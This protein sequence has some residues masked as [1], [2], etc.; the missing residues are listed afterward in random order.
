MS[1]YQ[2][3]V[4]VVGYVD[5]SIFQMIK[6]KQNTVNTGNTIKYGKHGQKP[7]V[8]KVLTLSESHSQSAPCFIL[9]PPVTIHLHRESNCDIYET[10]KAFKTEE[11]LDS[12]GKL[13]TL[14]SE[15]L[16]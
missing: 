16:V 13:L 10:L 12:K 2:R 4:I 5:P 7:Y 15:P 14:K 9:A 8:S 1:V 6:I 3:S 11:D